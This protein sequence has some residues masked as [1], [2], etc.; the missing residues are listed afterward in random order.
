MFLTGVGACWTEENQC[1]LNYDVLHHVNGNGKRGCKNCLI[2]AATSNQ[3]GNVVLLLK[4]GC[5]YSTF[6]FPSTISHERHSGAW[7][8]QL[9]R[10]TATSQVELEN[11]LLCCSNVA[12][13][14]FFTKK[15]SQS[16]STYLIIHKNTLSK[17]NH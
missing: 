4:R 11:V 2:Y 10:Y 5:E 17:S 16:M 7:L 8:Q 12:T 13:N 15:Q 3:T 1:H 14:T 6:E 9:S